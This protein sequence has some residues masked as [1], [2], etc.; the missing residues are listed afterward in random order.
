MSTTSTATDSRNSNR[1]IA[2]G[3]DTLELF[4][5]F[6]SNGRYV[7]RKKLWKKNGSEYKQCG[8]LRKVSEELAKLPYKNIKYFLISVGTND[9]DSK[10]HQ[11]VLGELERLIND[12]SVK[13]PGIKFIINEFLSI[14]FRYITN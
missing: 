9:L 12:T 13:Y 14:R 2:S 7:D 6:D 10:D 11:Q 3:N 8:T 4:L 5:C 1:T